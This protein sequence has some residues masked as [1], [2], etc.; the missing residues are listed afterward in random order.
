MH[1]VTADAALLLLRIT[2]IEQ[3][4]GHTLGEVAPQRRS[5]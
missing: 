3:L 4:E 1:K 5:Q 2:V